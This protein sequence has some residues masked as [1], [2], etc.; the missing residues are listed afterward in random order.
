MGFSFSTLWFF[1]VTDLHIVVIIPVAVVKAVKTAEAGGPVVKVDAA[2]ETTEVGV[3][4]VVGRLRRPRR[5]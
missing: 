4:K 1:A 2:S 3:V 5:E